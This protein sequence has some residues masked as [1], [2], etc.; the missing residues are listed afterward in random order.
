MKEKKYLLVLVLGLVLLLALSSVVTYVFFNVG[1]QKVRLA[2]GS[3][4][5][6]RGV[7]VT[8][9]RFTWN[10][11]PWQHSVPSFLQKILH[12]RNTSL[13]F[14][15]GNDD[16]IRLFLTRINPTNGAFLPECWRGVDVLDK[17]GFAYRSQVYTAGINGDELLEFDLKNYPRRER[18]FRIR[19][20]DHSGKK[21]VGEFIIQNPIPQRNAPIWMPDELPCTKTNGEA[22]V[23]L[24]CLKRVGSS[25]ACGFVPDYDIDFPG[26]GWEETQWFSDAT[27]NTGEVLSPQESVWKWHLRLTQTINDSYPSNKIL[28]FPIERIPPAGAFT[29]INQ[30]REIEGV[31]FH[32]ETLSGPG[33]LFISNN[34]DLATNTLSRYLGGPSYSISNYVEGPRFVSSILGKSKMD[35]VCS[36]YSFFIIEISDCPTNCDVIIRFC[37]DKGKIHLLNDV[38]PK[39]K[40]HGLDL[41]DSVKVLL[42]GMNLTKK[43]QFDGDIARMFFAYGTRANSCRRFCALPETNI[44]GGQLEIIVNKPKEFEFLVEPVLYSKEKKRFN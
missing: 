15:A 44:V 33:V 41:K 21:V 26:A 14:L 4:L 22:R 24:K 12:L 28:R 19:L 2:D 31:T 39:F 29:N 34:L 6:L 27:G 25:K 40:W 20:F 10:R 18:K 3:I 9:N 17:T 38:D 35:A 13:C 37:D 7:T 42:Q 16:G 32:L 30:T 11:T 1:Q 36:Q 8:T 23:S 43:I 5:V